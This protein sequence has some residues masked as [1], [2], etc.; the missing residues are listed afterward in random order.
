MTAVTMCARPH[1][2]GLQKFPAFNGLRGTI[3]LLDKAT[4]RWILSLSK[5]S[6]RERSPFLSEAVEPVFG[7]F[8]NNVI[9]A[10]SSMLFFVCLRPKSSKQL[11]DRDLGSIL[12]HQHVRLQRA[13][14]FRRR[15]SGADCKDQ[16]REPPSAARM[17]SW[18]VQY[19]IIAVMM[20]RIN[21]HNSE[22]VV[23]IGIMAA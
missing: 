16:R 9:Y 13:A 5:H 12:W 3:Q 15:T 20:N 7:Q 19:V 18:P 17:Q 10:R 14:C 6:R 23:T 22:I 8:L 21:K 2:A 4:G 1:A 11:P